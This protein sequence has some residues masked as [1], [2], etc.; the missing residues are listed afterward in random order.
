[1]VAAA[2]LTANAATEG[3]LVR[4]F[5]VLLNGQE[6]DSGNYVLKEETVTDENGETQNRLTFSYDGESGDGDLFVITG[7]TDNEIDDFAIDF[8]DSKENDSVYYQ[9]ID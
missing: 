6:L 1:M 8:G 4:N 9:I 3:E 2:M 7:E 5:I